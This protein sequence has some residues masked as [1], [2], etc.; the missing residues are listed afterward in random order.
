MASWRH[1]DILGYQELGFVSSDRVSQQESI[2]LGLFVSCPRTMMCNLGWNSAGM[3]Q[4]K[5]Q[6]FIPLRG[7]CSAG[8]GGSLTRSDWQCQ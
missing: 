1:F 6:K 8:A 7:L 5:L 2:L 3:T 4:I